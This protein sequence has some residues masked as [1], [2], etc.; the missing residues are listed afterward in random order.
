MRL[1]AVLFSLC[2]AWGCSSTTKPLDSTGGATG[3][4]TGAGGNTGDGGWQNV[5]GAGGV[6]GAAGTGGVAAGGAP[7]MGGAGGCVPLYLQAGCD[8]TPICNDGK[9]GAMACE[10]CDCTG[11]TRVSECRGA[12]VPFTSRVP[13]AP[14][15]VCGTDAGSQ[16]DTGGD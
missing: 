7:G 11:H 4:D 16:P 14:D 9:G 8:A 6:G 2:V 12:D 15:S 1:K 3:T 5:G 13:L 10:Y